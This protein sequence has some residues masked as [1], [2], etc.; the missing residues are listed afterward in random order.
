MSQT[1][2]LPVPGEVWASL[3]RGVADR[4]SPFRTP[5]LATTSLDGLP[6]VRTVVLRGADVASRTLTFHS[7]LRSPKVA[8]LGRRPYAA[9]M[10]YDRRGRIQ[11]RASG[12]T[13]IEA[14]GAL[15]D[16][17]WARTTASARRT[18]ATATGPGRPVVPGETRSLDVDS[19]EVRAVFCQGRTRVERIDWLHL[20]HAGHM[21]AVLEWTGTDWAV[22]WRVP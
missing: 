20:H 18:Y 3:L 6:E 10:F 21:R 5:A 1:P 7:D 9:W 14:G 16:A 4:R 2:S 13:T 15:V 12:P 19:P 22:G 11:I 17:A 8:A